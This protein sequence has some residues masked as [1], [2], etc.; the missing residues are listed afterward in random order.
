MNFGLAIV[1]VIIL[2]IAYRSRSESLLVGNE[3]VKT[4]FSDSANGHTYYY[5][6]TGGHSLTLY[7]RSAN[8]TIWRAAE[9]IDPSVA[10]FANARATALP[11][12][13]TVGTLSHNSGQ[14][15]S[16]TFWN[17]VPL[18]SY[19][20][21]VTVLRV[22]FYPYTQGFIT[23]TGMTLSTI[24]SNAV[25][26]YFI[27]G[28]NQFFIAVE[29]RGVS[30]KYLTEDQRTTAIGTVMAIYRLTNAQIDMIRGQASSL[31]EVVLNAVSYEYV[32]R[33][34]RNALGFD[35]STRFW[36]PQT[37]AAVTETVTQ[38]SGVD[39]AGYDVRTIQNTSLA[40]CKA[41]STTENALGYSHAGNT[42]YLKRG[43]YNPN[44]V[45]GVRT[46]S[47]GWASIPN[48]DLPLTAGTIENGVLESACRVTAQNLNSPVYI[49]DTPARRCMVKRLTANA[50]VT[51]GFNPESLPG[52]ALPTGVSNLDNIRNPAGTI[53]RVVGNVKRIYP[54]PTV[55]SSW[56]NPPNRQLS[57][58]DFNSIFTGSTMSTYALPAG[59]TNGIVIRYNGVNAYV[60][61]NR[62]RHYASDIDYQWNHY[63]DDW[64]N[65]DEA[66]WGNTLQGPNMTRFNTVY[67]GG[68]NEGDWCM[69][70]LHSNIYAG[71]LTGGKLNLYVGSELTVNDGAF[72]RLTWRDVYMLYITNNIKF[73]MGLRNTLFNMELLYESAPGFLYAT[74]GDVVRD[75]KSG[76]ISR[77]ESRE[78][79]GGSIIVS[80]KFTRRHYTWEAWVSW[81]Y[82]EFRNIH[83]QDYENIPEGIPMPLNPNNY[84]NVM[85]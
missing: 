8:G 37:V 75:V 11:N 61:N 81:G 55:Y 30:S 67:P 82:P 72:G 65:V 41:S 13:T 38:V 84:N 59:V 14:V 1:I 74:Y 16:M 17:P 40:Q 85:Y 77:I 48:V 34:S 78:V 6:S 32:S 4:V 26:R 35:P 25:Y 43:R 47:G 60:E 46:V 20:A 52:W 18:T 58:A 50:A 9:Y 24:K 22:P 31:N 70:I 2:L 83:A 73:M 45:M 23:G 3:L 12:Q 54:N 27:N 79:T 21:G 56:G 28:V 10:D 51:S 53:A 19:T 64:V 7:V 80:Y 36:S 69:V 5:S 66:T 42:C 63:I 44:T 39:F 71:R 15:T 49:Y 29:H 68:F 33:G 57:D 76:A 62:R